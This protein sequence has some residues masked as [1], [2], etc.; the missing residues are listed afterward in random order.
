[1]CDSFSVIFSYLWN[2]ML[3]VGIIIDFQ[4]II[5]D[6]ALLMLSYPHKS[7][8]R[9]PILTPAK[10]PQIHMLSTNN[11]IFPHYQGF[12]CHTGNKNEANKI[13]SAFLHSPAKRFPDDDN[14]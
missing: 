6:S 13:N 11:S 10:A 8:Q 4:C 7:P 14:L 5:N 3:I 1:M 9:Q 12:L 2:T